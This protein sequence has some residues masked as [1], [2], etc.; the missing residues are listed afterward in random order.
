VLNRLLLVTTKNDDN[1]DDAVV[2]PIKEKCDKDDNNIT[3][4]DDIHADK[5]NT[6]SREIDLTM[7]GIMNKMKK[8]SCKE[9][10]GEDHVYH[11]DSTSIDPV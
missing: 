8:E 4:G 7:D 2:H 3:S 11:S 1:E 6:H 5:K 9:W 10:L